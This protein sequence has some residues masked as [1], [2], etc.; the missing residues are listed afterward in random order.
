MKAYTVSYFSNSE[1]EATDGVCDVCSTKVFA[2]KRVSAHIDDFNDYIT[3]IDNDLTTTRIYTEQGTY[4]IEKF[5]IDDEISDTDKRINALMEE[6]DEDE[7][8][9]SWD[10]VWTELFNKFTKGE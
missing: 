6:E 5:E 8:Y 3:D 7:G 2:M 1:R 9:R 4:L 10:T